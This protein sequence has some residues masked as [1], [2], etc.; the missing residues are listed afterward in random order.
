[1]RV[2]AALD[3]FQAGVREGNLDRGEIGHGLLA[4]TVE[5]DDDPGLVVAGE[6]ADADAVAKNDRAVTQRVRTNRRHRDDLCARVNE[7]AAG[8][9][10][11]GGRASRRREDQAVAVV[12]R[13]EFVIGQHLESDEV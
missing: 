1:M 8:R 2:V 7:W 4:L 11:V 6:N 13:H 3:Q 5:G 10:I 9:E 12:L